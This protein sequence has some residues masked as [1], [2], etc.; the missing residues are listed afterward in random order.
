MNESPIEQLLSA[1][2]RLDLD[3]AMS[4]V[5]PGV[6][7]LIA[8]GRR[9]EGSE[10]VRELM[11][12]VIGTLR[13]TSHR[14]TAQWHQGDAWIAEVQASYELS[15]WLELKALPRAFVVRQG[16]DGI[17]ELHVYGAHEHP[18]SEHRAGNEGLRVGERWIPPL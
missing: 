13:S 9:A 3:A 16:A 12:S 7:A 10:A 8:D 1:F 18:L 6:Q 5:A 4:L 15:D 11:A 17:T 2:D 14:I